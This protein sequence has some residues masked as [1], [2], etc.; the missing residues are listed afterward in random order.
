M[1]SLNIRNIGNELVKRLKS[2]AALAG[3]TLREY[4]IGKLENDRAVDV[5]RAAEVPARKRGAGTSER[6]SKPSPTCP[7]GKEKGYHCG[8]CGGLAKVGE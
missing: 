8:L 4:V 5:P 6:V 3:V 2:E 1:P 7:H